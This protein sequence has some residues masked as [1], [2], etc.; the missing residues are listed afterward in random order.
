MADRPTIG[1]TSFSPGWHERRPMSEYLAD[2]AASASMLWKLHTTTPAHFI[3]DYGGDE[4]TVA[5]RLGSVLHARL[6][7]PATFDQYVVLGPC[8]AEL[9]SGERK[10]EK[11]GKQGSVFRDGHSFCGTQ[12]HDPYGKDEPM[13]PGIEV[14]TA[15]QKR[16]AIAM[17]AALRKDREINELLEAEGPREVIGVWQDKET[18]LWLRIRPDML[19]AE[20]A[21]TPARWHW[22]VPNLKSTGKVA[23]GE[24]FRRDFENLGNHFKAAVYRLG[25]RELWPVEPQNFLYPTVET[26]A[27]YATILHRIHEDWLDIAEDDVRHTLRALAD[28]LDADH[29]PA[30]GG[31]IHDL[32]LPEWRRKRLDVIDDV[33]EVAA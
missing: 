4:E 11:C 30:Y 24:A 18:G 26:Y 14:V 27:P 12:G 32:N 22:S 15:S 6:F 33:V 16:D 7:E 1:T 21:A 2:P 17:E 19:I 25:M 13:A 31:G 9:K 20:P 23:R 3:E 29:W 10:G 28:C 5:K 8:E